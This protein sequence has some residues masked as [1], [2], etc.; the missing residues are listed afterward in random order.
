[1][2]K[3]TKDN[4]MAFKDKDDLR[5]NFEKYKKAYKKAKENYEY[6]QDEIEEGNALRDMEIAKANVKLIKEYLES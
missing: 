3:L 4:I 6:A 5:V 2:K 1:M